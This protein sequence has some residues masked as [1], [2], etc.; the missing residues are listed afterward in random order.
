MRDIV[1]VV[2]QSNA[3]RLGRSL[4]GLPQRA[5][6]L[7][8]GPLKWCCAFVDSVLSSKFFSKIP[9]PLSFCGVPCLPFSKIPLARGAC[10]DYLTESSR[11]PWPSADDFGYWTRSD[12]KRMGLLRN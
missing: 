6:I 4:I 11:S 8:H 10:H 3:P 5:L 12:M 2:V 9:F 7:Y 1:K